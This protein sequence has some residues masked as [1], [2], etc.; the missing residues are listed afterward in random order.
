M[1]VMFILCCGKLLQASMRES[2][3]FAVQAAQGAEDNEN[4][5]VQ[6]TASGGAPDTITLSATMA[7]VAA[8]EQDLPSRPPCHSR[9]GHNLGNVSYSQSAVPRVHAVGPHES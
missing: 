1:E 5:G 3:A 6:D 2:T 9:Y 8:T 4:Q 7:V